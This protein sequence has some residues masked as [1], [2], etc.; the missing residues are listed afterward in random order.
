MFMLIQP[1]IRHNRRL[2]SPTPPPTD[3]A[4]LER[5]GRR[6]RSARLSRNWSQAALARE[7]GISKRTLERLEAG[8]SAQL[9]SLIR[10]LRALG[11]LDRLDALLPSTRPDPIELLER[12]G[13]PPVRASPAPDGDRIHPASQPWSW[14]D[15]DG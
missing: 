10:V 12:G 4:I 3:R 9:T 8:E 6:L 7:A 13:R 5:I 2:V 14:G 11:L 15:A 1:G